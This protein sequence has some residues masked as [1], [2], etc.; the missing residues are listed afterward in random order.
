MNAHIY[1]RIQYM[2]TETH[3]YNAHMLKMDSHMVRGINHLILL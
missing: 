3:T 2:Q 1:A